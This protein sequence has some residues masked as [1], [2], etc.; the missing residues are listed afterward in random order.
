VRIALLTFDFPEYCV[1]LAS[2][3]AEEAETLLIMPASDAEPLAHLLDPRVTL[4]TFDKP[5]LRHPRRQWRTVRQ[6]LRAIHDFAPDVLHLQQGHLWFNLLALPRLRGVPLVVT[7]HD[8]RH[9]PGDA[10]S[11]RTPQSV[12]DFGFRRA[13]RLIVHADPL[14]RDLIAHLGAS[15]ERVHVVPHIAIGGDR[16]APVTE[17]RDGTVL[18]FGR[19]WPYKGLDVLIRAEPSVSER[20]PHARFVI[21]GTGEDFTRYRRMMVHPDRFEVHN[22]FVSDEQRTELFAQ[23]SV[24]V[25]PY[26]EASQSGVVPVAYAAGKPVVATRVGG[27]PEA[28]RHGE[29]GL[30]VAPGDEGALADALVELLRDGARRRAMGAAGRRMQEAEFGPAVVAARTLDVYRAAISDGAS[31][32]TA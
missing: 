23:A 25:L 14:K 30:L 6:Q 22:A 27:L 17:E 11:Q 28:V 12:H 13:R 20:A 15:E 21:A 7:V 24:V 8:V 9:H 31:P 10:A 1:R 19:I 3:L 18:F 32:R 4:R 29:T 5:R 26:V 2:A 16:P